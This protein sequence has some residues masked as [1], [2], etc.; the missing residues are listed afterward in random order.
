MFN[1][2]NEYRGITAKVPFIKLQTLKTF[3]AKEY[4]VKSISDLISLLV[5]EEYKRIQDINYLID[6]QMNRELKLKDN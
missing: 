6:K 4:N 1:H 2:K 3:Y 5:C